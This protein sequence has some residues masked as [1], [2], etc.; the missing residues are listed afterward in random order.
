MEA[1]IQA[2]AE[3]TTDNFLKLN[4]SKCEVIAFGMSEV[5]V[6]QSLLSIDTI[7]SSLSVRN[8]GK[9][10]AIYFVEI[11]SVFW[12]NDSGVGLESIKGFFPF[13]SVLCF[14]RQ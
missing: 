9:V 3:F 5:N 11:K 1:Q 10:W 12:C 7:S 4:A 14:P 13:G 6:V 8:E 2:V